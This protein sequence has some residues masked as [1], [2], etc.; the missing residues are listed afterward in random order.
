M[1]YYI[2]ADV[3]AFWLFFY[4]VYVITPFDL[5]NRDSKNI[6]QIRKFDKYMSPVINLFVFLFIQVDIAWFFLATGTIKTLKNF[7]IAHLLFDAVFFFC[8]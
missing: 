4:L 2:F 8:L 3:F 6:E 7:I 1:I 5:M